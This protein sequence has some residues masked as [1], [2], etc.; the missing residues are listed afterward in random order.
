MKM[1]CKKHFNSHLQKVIF[2]MMSKYGN[3]LNFISNCCRSSVYYRDVFTGVAK[4]H[5]FFTRML[6]Y[7]P[8]LH[9]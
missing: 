6:I 3:G 5:M 9:V 2:R 4:I 7:T 1:D 8:K